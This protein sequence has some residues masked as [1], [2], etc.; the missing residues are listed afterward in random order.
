MCF[1]FFQV[2]LT[3]F[4]EWSYLDISIVF[5]S[6]PFDHSLSLIFVFDIH[7]HSFHHSLSLSFHHV[8][9]RF[10]CLLVLHPLLLHSLPTRSSLLITLPVIPSSLAVMFSTPL[11]SFFP[12]IHPHL[13]LLV[14]VCFWCAALWKD[15]NPVG[16]CALVMR[17][18]VLLAVNVFLFCQQSM[19]HLA[20]KLNYANLNDELLKHFARLQCRDAEVGLCWRMRF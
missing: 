13:F 5:V 15:W 4:K 12:T 20:P 6:L 18:D 16:D 17:R 2:L 11:P 1:R 7:C 10:L 8:M 14:C 9:K 3:Y 19:L